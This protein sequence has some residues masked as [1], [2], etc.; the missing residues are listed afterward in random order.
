MKIIGIAFLIML[1][2]SALFYTSMAQWGRG[3]RRGGFGRRGFGGGFG[4]RGFRGGFRGGFRRGWR[5]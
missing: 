2:L 1:I 3:F 5:G 4:G